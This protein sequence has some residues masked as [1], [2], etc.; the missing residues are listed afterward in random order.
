M[1]LTAKQK[2]RIKALLGD[3]VEFT[4]DNA[5]DLVLDAAETARKAKPTGKAD[6]VQLSRSE[7]L[8]RVL[9]AFGISKSPDEVVAM[10]D[11]DLKTLAA[12]LS[13][14][15]NDGPVPVKRDPLVM[16]Q[17]AKGFKAEKESL[18]SSGA[19]DKATADK[20]ENLFVQNGIPS[21]IALSQSSDDDDPMLSRV[22]DALKG[23][24]PPKLGE[25]SKGQTLLS[26]SNPADDDDDDGDGDDA[27]Q[28]EINRAAGV[29]TK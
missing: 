21:S 29:K 12:E 26:R 6:K 14:S 23:N 27:W 10:Q 11:A 13:R 7:A 1:P 2:E 24:K 25:T 28:K 20:L 8:D 9:T 17:L 18:I 19:V 16:R 4:D 15:S 22:W 5:V 3:A